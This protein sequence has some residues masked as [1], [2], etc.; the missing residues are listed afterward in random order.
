MVVSYK[1]VKRAIEQ[2][3]TECKVGEERVTIE[4]WI[5]NQE[6]GEDQSKWSFNDWAEICVRGA[7]YRRKYFEEM[8][9]DVSDLETET[10]IFNLQPG[11]IR[12]ESSVGTAKVMLRKVDGVPVNGIPAEWQKVKEEYKNEEHA[13]GVYSPRIAIDEEAQR[14]INYGAWVL[15]NEKN[16]CKAMVTGSRVT[17]SIL[18]KSKDLES[19]SKFDYW[20]K[21][22][23]IEIL[24]KIVP[25]KDPFC[26]LINYKIKT[27]GEF[28]YLRG[29]FFVG[30]AMGMNMAT[31]QSD[32]YGKCLAGEAIEGMRMEDPEIRGYMSLIRALSENLGIKYLTVSSNWC[33]DKK[34]NII[35]IAEGRGETVD[36]V[37]EL[38]EEF[39]NSIGTSSRE[40]YNYFSNMVLRNP[41]NPWYR[42]NVV[43]KIVAGFFVHGQDMAQ[44]LESTMAVQ[45]VYL[46]GDGV[47]YTLQLPSLMI[48]THGGGVSFNPSAGK[49]LHEIGCQ[50]YVEGKGYRGFNKK[51]ELGEIIATTAAA[52]EIGYV[53]RQLVKDDASM[54]EEIQYAEVPVGM[55][56]NGS[57]LATTET[58]LVGGANAGM[59]LINENDG[60]NVKVDTIK[61]YEDG[62][63]EMYAECSIK[64]PN[65]SF[66]ANK[67]HYTNAREMANLIQ[68]KCYTGTTIAGGGRGSENT[69]IANTVAAMQ[70][71]YEQPLYLIRQNSRGSIVP[72]LTPE[73]DIN[74]R[75]VMYSLRLYPYKNYS[76]KE[77]AEKIYLP[78]I[79]SLETQTTRT[80]AAGTLAGDHTGHT[81]KQFK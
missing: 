49:F 54:D 18:I 29:E 55:L 41:E 78:T 20:F 63:A 40:V 26:S 71:A 3:Q 4:K 11:L 25:Q 42:Y 77:L 19:A 33:C 31:Q 69:N 23:G 44:T 43:G 24:K 62:S 74:I 60:F 50:E 22:E 36:A 76:P 10:K 59:G 72:T 56:Q 48:A 28:S 21:K 39:L 17:R 64:I 68:A 70:A 9:F 37:C 57:R 53:L 15:G 38:S 75:I 47:K 51:F 80:Q 46:T 6:L 61:E 8:G 67:R 35:N 81:K 45:N 66:E 5:A 14:S 2:K 34:Q 7:A 32:D 16:S 73:G 79:T 12:I 13:N 30:S 27:V 1:D 58:L 65:S 52:G